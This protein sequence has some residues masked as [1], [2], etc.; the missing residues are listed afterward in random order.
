MPNI[1]DIQI[2]DPF[3]LRQDGN[4]Y[5]Y[6]TTD[7]DVWRGK[8]IGF[9]VY[10]AKDDDF[11]EFAGPY[12]AFRP[13]DDFYSEM[14]FWAPEVHVYEEKFYMLATFWHKAGQRG[15]AIL[16]AD[17]PLGPFTPWSDGLVTPMEWCCLDGTLH[18]EN[19]VP[20]MV[21]C[22]EW[23]QITDGSICYLPLSMDLK[24]ATGAP[25]TLFHASEATWTDE[26]AHRG[27]GIYV[28]DGPFLYR[29]ETGELYMFWSSY[30]NG[31]YAIGVSKS[32]NKRIDGN[33]IHGTSPLYGDDG[34]HGM[35]FEKSGKLYLTI[36][37]PNDS[38]NERANFVELRDDLS[39]TRGDKRSLLFD[40]Q[41]EKMG[42]THGWN[43][44]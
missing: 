7:P 38:P 41:T 33:W 14:N 34:G 4:Y 3:I 5:L 27:P 44:L 42:N 11:I 16:R 24:K 21:F 12:P 9:D 22:H 26:M 15:T 29:D 2:R 37:R 10:I 1:K 6:G 28:T 23:Q 30:S 43:L 18:L 13:A 8:G 19:E 36:H 25:V 20:Y 17:N 40:L 32:D 31:K 35:V 39:C